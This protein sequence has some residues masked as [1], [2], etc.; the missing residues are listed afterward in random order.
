MHGLCLYRN[1]WAE[2]RVPLGT[3]KGGVRDMNH[4]S[5]AR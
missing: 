4:P 3:S 2:G 1:S 5:Y